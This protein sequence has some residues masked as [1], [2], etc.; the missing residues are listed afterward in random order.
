M[1]ISSNIIN[2]G[3]RFDS[4]NSSLDQCFNNLH[5]K[6]K[7]YVLIENNTGVLVDDSNSINKTTGVQIGD[8][9]IIEVNNY[10]NMII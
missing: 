7:Y 4:K 9:N 3:R 10:S 1:T 6:A 8:R 5:S 2:I